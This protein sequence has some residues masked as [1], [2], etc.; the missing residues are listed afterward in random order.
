[1]V[2]ALTEQEQA[3][4]SILRQF[5]PERLVEVVDFIEFL[6]QRTEIEDEKIITYV[7]AKLSERSFARLWDNDE[8]A[9]YDR[10]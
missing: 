7:T 2:S 4:I 5:P 1:M 6:K 8:D 9:I 10:L 3:I